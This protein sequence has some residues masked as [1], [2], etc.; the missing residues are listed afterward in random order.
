MLGRRNDSQHECHVCLSLGPKDLRSEGS[1]KETHV[2]VPSNYRSVW[3]K[4]VILGDCH[5]T[6][7]KRVA[8]LGMHRSRDKQLNVHS[9]PYSLYTNLESRQYRGRKSIE[10]R[11]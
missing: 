2:P 11:F 3:P 10:E 5:E 4:G 8:S 7:S 9:V 1:I 6:V